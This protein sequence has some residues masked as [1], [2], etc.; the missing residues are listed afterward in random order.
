MEVTSGL[1]ESC[2]SMGVVGGV[3]AKA[4]RHSMGGDGE[5]GA[6]RDGMAAGRSLSMGDGNI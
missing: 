4:G 3:R 2:A 5:E 6:Q 1:E